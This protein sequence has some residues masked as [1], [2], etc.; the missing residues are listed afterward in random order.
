MQPEM[1]DLRCARNS[2]V[3]EEEPP[4]SWMRLRESFL[5]DGTGE[6]SMLCTTPRVLEEIKGRFSELLVYIE[7]LYFTSCCVRQLCSVDLP[8]VSL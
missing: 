1:M 7:V 8:K 6:T 2:K 4:N 5:I 3:P